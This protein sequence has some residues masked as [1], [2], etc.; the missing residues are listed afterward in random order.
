MIHYMHDK[1]YYEAA[2]MSLIDTDVK[3]SFATGIAGFSHV[4]DSFA[5]SNTLRL[6]LFVTKTES[7]QI[8][9]SKETSQ[10]TVT[11]MIVQMTWLSG[12]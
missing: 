6:K 7:Q 11:M 5:L 4:V 10:D 1:Y 12:F 9:K 2:Q 8:S 3:R